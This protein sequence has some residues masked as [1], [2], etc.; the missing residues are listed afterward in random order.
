MSIRMMTAVY[1]SGLPKNEKAIALKYADFATDDGEG[2]YPAV[3]RV[4]WETG[5]SDR[6]V[7]RITQNLLDRGVMIFIGVHPHYGTNEYKLNEKKLPK[8]PSY[9]EYLASRGDKMSGVTKC[10]GGDICDDEGVTFATDGG[11]MVSPD[12]LLDPLLKQTP[13]DM[14]ST[15]YENNIGM[16]TPLIHGHLETAVSTYGAEWVIDA[17]VESSS[18]GARHWNY[19]ATVLRNWSIEGRGSKNGKN[20]RSA[21]VDEINLDASMERLKAEGI[22]FVD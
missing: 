12:P 13:L 19:A 5:Y 7:Q 20:G 15:V 9:A 14:V 17:L 16:I 10:R 3:G 8:R 1:E 11:D 21:K 4:A 18:R 6:Q 22:V 2:V